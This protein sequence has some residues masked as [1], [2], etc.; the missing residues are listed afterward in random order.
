MD[1]DA[2][3]PIGELARRTGLSVKAIRY[4]SDRGIVTPADRSPA[5]Y[6][7]YGAE[8]QARLELVRTLR[9]LGI[10]LATIGRVVDAETSLPEVAAAHAEALAVQLRVLRR[11]HTVLATAARRNSSPTELA[12][13][14]SLARLSTVERGELIDDFLGTALGTREPH[15][16]LDAARRSMTPE[17]PD[18]PDDEQLAAWLELAGLAR[19]PD[20]RDHLRDLAEQHVSER[21]PGETVVTRDLIATVRD[22][23]APA[24]AARID[25]SA[26]EAEPVLA[27]VT[28]Q[29]A[30][31][32]GRPDDAELRAGLLP[33]LA[34]AN[35][36]R[37]ER[38]GQLL[39]IINR[40]AAPSSPAPAIDW[41]IQALR[42]ADQLDRVA[43][44]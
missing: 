14:H 16:E 40:W 11:R 18:E 22:L 33:R 8:A 25:P 6:R 1:D 5:G 9:E 4:Y 28:A 44:V 41:C 39:A 24:L 7:R 13:I 10:D 27:T 31:I 2:R 15:P 36:P 34:A 35:D 3:Y 43:Q 42:R 29:Y 38:Y 12:L 19:D 37:R 30:A 17:L 26:P 23:V 21:V 32:V 20:F